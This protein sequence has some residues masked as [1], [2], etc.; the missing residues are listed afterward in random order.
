MTISL[1]YTHLCPRVLIAALSKY[2]HSWQEPSKAGASFRLLTDINMDSLT[3]QLIPPCFRTMIFPQ[4]WWYGKP[5]KT[6]ES[7]I[8]DTGKHLDNFKHILKWSGRADV[9]GESVPYMFFQKRMS[10]HAPQR[11]SGGDT[12]ETYLTLLYY[13]YRLKGCACGL[14]KRYTLIITSIV[15]QV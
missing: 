11:E 6:S 13:A 1:T 2:K 3:Q 9:G 7:Y 8:R 5:F 10:F 12:L 15:I 14:K 4:A